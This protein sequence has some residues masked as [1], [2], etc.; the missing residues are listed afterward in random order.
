MQLWYFDHKIYKAKLNKENEFLFSFF[1]FP[2]MFA[3]AFTSKANI[4]Y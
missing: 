4:Q 1:S 3:Q 2:L